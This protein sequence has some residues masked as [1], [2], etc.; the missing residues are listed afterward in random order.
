MAKSCCAFT[1]FC[2]HDPNCSAI[3]ECINSCKDDEVCQA[4]CI[5]NGDE[6]AARNLRDAVVCMT[7]NCAADC[8][9]E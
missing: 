3:I 7:N 1:F 9:G 2:D 8:G 6:F 5:D 4:H